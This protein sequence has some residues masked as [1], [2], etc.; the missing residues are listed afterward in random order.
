MCIRDRYGA[1]RQEMMEFAR[2]LVLV[3]GM[4]GTQCEHLE[5][6]LIMDV[7]EYTSPG[8][9]FRTR[10]YNYSLPGPPLRVHAGDTVNLTFINRLGE[11]D[12]GEPADGGEPPSVW[13]DPSNCTTQYTP[14]RHPNT[15]NLHTHG[16]HISPLSPSDDVLSVLIPPQ[17]QYTYQYH[18]PADHM[19]GT[20]WY[21]PHLSL[22]HISEPTRLLSISY[23][24]FCLK[25]KKRRR[26]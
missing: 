12:N 17:T 9:S 26:E 5:F 22:I 19:A 16:L 20:F 3:L 11:R 6:T 15:T 10:A 21:H 24:V 25:K 8:I 13:C 23:A 18:I 2:M 7:L 14:Y 1:V 4:A